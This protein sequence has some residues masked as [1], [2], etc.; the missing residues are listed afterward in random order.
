MPGRPTNEPTNY[1]AQG[2]QSAK[3]TEAT[4]FFFF[5][6][7]DG[8]GF[9]PDPDVQSER[10][11]GD[12]QE[13]GLR[14]KSLIKA[15]G[16]VFSNSRVGVLGRI[17]SWTLGQDTV[18]SQAIG[19]KHTIVPVGSAPYIT[20]DQRAADE[21][22]RTTNNVFTGFTL[23][24]EAGRPWKISGQFVNGGSYYDRPL[25][26]ALTPT[27]ET[28]PPFM[29]PGGTYTIDGV[30]TAKLTKF[31]VVVRR[32]VD[33][34]IQTVALNREDVIPLTFEADCNFTLKYED[35]TLY[36]KIQYGGGSQVPL[37]LAT[38]AFSAFTQ[39]GSLTAKVTLPWIQY[40]GAKPNSLDPDG[41][42][43][44][45]DVA[46]MTVKPPI[47]TSS[48]IVEINDVPNATAAYTSP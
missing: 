15:D 35:R 47:A 38:G 30:G 22:E 21:L 29:M 7:L 14:Y 32:G 9:D 37:D 13:V 27:R 46:A 39:Q 31:E 24:G 19:Q 17:T 8:T 25:A 23:S 4:T 34:G 43:V 10:E 16:Q 28:G 33:D 41:R 18:A 5:K 26:S 44:Y 42:T 11:G 40:V 3:D 2:V 45:I 36:A 1:F 6:H 48:V 12:G 20:T